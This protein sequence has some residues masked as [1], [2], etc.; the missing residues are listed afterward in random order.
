M[1]DGIASFRFAMAMLSSSKQ[2]QKMRRGETSSR[3]NQ[4]REGN[5]RPTVTTSVK[6]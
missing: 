2:T 5:L 6:R 3:R 1:G 4:C